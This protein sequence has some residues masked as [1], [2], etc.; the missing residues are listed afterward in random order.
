MLEKSNEIKS[1]IEGGINMYITNTT[2]NV[3]K[4]IEDLLKKDDVAKLKFLIYLFDL[5]THQQINSKNEANPDLVED[6]DL[7]IFNL[8]DAGMTNNYGDIYLEYLVMV[9][10]S[11][12]TKLSKGYQ[13]NGNVEGIHYNKYDKPLLSKFEKLSYNEKLDVFAEIFIRLD[14]D[15]LFENKYEM[16]TLNTS[17]FDIASNITNLKIKENI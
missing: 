3:R 4:V 17:G 2:E 12:A 9:F 5:A 14:N 16:L 1:N 10:N 7:I 11:T 8:E 13:D 6:D 15:N